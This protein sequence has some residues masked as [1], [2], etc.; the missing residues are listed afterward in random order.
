MTRAFR[1]VV[2]AALGV[3]AWLLAT[4]AAQAFE[5]IAS[6]DVAAVVTSEG[7][8][9]VTET[10][11]YDFHSEERHGIYRAIPYADEL[12]NGQLW[13]HD[14]TVTSV[15][16]DGAPV[17]YDVNDVGLLREIKIG[18]P[19]V[20]ITGSHVY[21]ISYT[22]AGSLRPL[23]QEELAESNPYGFAPGDVELYWDFIGTDWYAP[24]Y[25][26]TVSVRG[27]GSVLAAECFT[28][29]VGATTPCRD[30]IEGTGVTFRHDYLGPG[31]A[32]TGVVAYPGAAFTTPP[33]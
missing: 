8:M 27:P 14:I 5:T 16:M 13:S 6:Y 26:V 29:T 32:L 17:P 23:T 7:D 22:V 19:D 15:T 30:R 10:I 28:G 12:P 18:D 11:V 21:V 9:N 25:S 2:A 33:I 3:A 24:I 4:T 1:W 31:Q 20:T